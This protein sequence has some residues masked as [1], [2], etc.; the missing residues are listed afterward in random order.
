M[1]LKRLSIFSFSLFLVGC[2]TTPAPRNVDNICTIFKT[3]PRWY[4]DSLDVERR[5]L[6]PVP[7]QMAIVHQ[8]SKFDAQARPPRKKLLW[9][10]PWT[11]PT[12]AY[13]YSQ[14]LDGTWAEYRKSPAGSYFARRDSFGDAL[15]FIGWYANDAHKRAGISRSDAYN[16]YLAYHEGVGGYMRKSYLKKPWLIGVSRKVKLRSQIYASQL[17]SCKKNLDNDAWF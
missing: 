13:G 1:F 5:W 3:Y 6:V 7:V 8:E 10:I 14:A 16:L 9:I 4:R 17:S 2:V 11:R 12:T 15:D